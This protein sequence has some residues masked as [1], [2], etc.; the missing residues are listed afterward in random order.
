MSVITISA[1]F[2]GVHILLDE[3]YTLEPSARLLVTVLPEEDDE[4]DAWLQLSAESL[5][6]VSDLDEPEY[7]ISCVREM[8]PCYDRR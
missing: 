7:P 2:D 4:R 3:P 5:A 1:H 8:N 6:R